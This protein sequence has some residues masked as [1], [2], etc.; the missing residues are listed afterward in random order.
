MDQWGKKR[1]HLEYNFILRNGSNRKSR[2]NLEWD[3][4][5][6][7]VQILILICTPQWDVLVCRPW[8]WQSDHDPRM[9]KMISS[10]SMQ[11]LVLVYKRWRDDLVCRHHDELLFWGNMFF[12]LVGR[13]VSPAPNQ[14]ST[15]IFSSVP[16][17]LQ[18]CQAQIL[19]R[20]LFEMMVWRRGRW[21]PS[22][23]RSLFCELFGQILVKAS[24]VFSP[25]VAKI[26]VSS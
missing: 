4:Y 24:S 3:T 2:S 9:Q 14:Q 7:L 23:P 12:S 5:M 22:A 8:F 10:S 13:G 15:P 11:P 26:F 19:Q 17:N 20:I 25:L 16:S 6:I 1:T 21:T 18:C